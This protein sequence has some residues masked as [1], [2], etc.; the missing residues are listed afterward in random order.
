M[1]KL[2]CVMQNKIIVRIFKRAA[3]I[4]FIEASFIRRKRNLQSLQLSRSAFVSEVKIPSIVRHCNHLRYKRIDKSELHLDRSIY[5]RGLLR[6]QCPSYLL[7]SNRRLVECVLGHLT[8]CLKKNK[9]KKSHCMISLGLCNKKNYPYLV[10]Y[11][12]G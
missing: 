3:V 2:I 6:L 9:L 11:S 7:E 8:R 10:H 1:Y 5:S 12:V 4:K